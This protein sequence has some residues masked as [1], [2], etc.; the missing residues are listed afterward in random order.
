[1]KEYEIVARFYNA[2]GGSSRPQTF[3]EEAELNAPED[4]VRTK[5]G[6]DFDKF[7]REISPEGEI[8]FRYDN[9]SICY[10]YAFTEI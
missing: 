8:V 3:F 9:G 6:K 7:S 4:Y 2:C 1:M 10:V 5:H